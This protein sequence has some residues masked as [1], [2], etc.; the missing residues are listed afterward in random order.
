MGY[1]NAHGLIQLT[2]GRK[3]Q[4]MKIKLVFLEI[5]HLIFL[6]VNIL[7]VTSDCFSFRKIDN[8]DTVYLILWATLFF[9]TFALS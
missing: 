8:N 3:S 9:I 6:I 5:K 4:L 1:M 7:H 2:I